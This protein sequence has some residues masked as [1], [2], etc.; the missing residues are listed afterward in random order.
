MQTFTSL[1]MHSYL[2]SEYTAEE[3]LKHISLIS[4]ILQINQ[5]VCT[6]GISALERYV[7][8]EKIPFL[9]K[10]GLYLVWSGIE[11]QI[12]EN[13]LLNIALTN[14]L[15]LLLSLLIIEA[16][17]SIQQRHSPDITKELLL[18]YFKIEV[19][20]EIEQRTAKLEH[21]F[22]E[23]LNKEQIQELLKHNC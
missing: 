3:Q 10:K 17:L 5:D 11:P 13:V 1:A 18:S 6:S 21:N 4:M 12:V 9:L 16:V 2:H 8:D 23:P 7:D 19:V 14:K 20:D 15:D 22:S